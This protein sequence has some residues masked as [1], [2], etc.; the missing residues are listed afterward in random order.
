MEWRA[1]GK[2][3]ESIAAVMDT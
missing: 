3:R 1:A 2:F